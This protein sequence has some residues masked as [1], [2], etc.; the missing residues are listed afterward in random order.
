MYS[1]ELNYLIHFRISLNPGP[2]SPNNLLTAEVLPTPYEWQ[3]QDQRILR[4]IASKGK[5]NETIC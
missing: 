5:S 1:N 4:H 2:V 3:L